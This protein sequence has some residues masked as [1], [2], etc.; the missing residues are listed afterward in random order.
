MTKS[1]PAIKKG[2]K[3]GRGGGGGAG[4]GAECLAVG[5]RWAQAEGRGKLPQEME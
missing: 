3:A 2:G 4:R 5:G 1:C